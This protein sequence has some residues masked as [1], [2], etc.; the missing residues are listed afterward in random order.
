MIFFGGFKQCRFMILLT[1]FR[2]KIVRCLALVLINHRVFL[3]T[4]LTPQPEIN[5]PL[6][7]GY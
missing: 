2:E 7:M 1:D 3:N 4:H 5:F 6:I